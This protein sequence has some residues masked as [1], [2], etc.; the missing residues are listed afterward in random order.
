MDHESPEVIS[1]RMAQTRRDLTEKVVTLEGVVRDAVRDTSSAVRDQFRSTVDGAKE[2]ADAVAG[3]VR[4]ALDVSG[5]VRSHPWPMVAGSFTAGFITGCLPG[6]ASAPAAHTA[7][8]S[9]PRPAGPLDT[10]LSR[11]TDELSKS[12]LGLIQSVSAGLQRD[13]PGRLTR[14]MDRLDEP[15]AR[16]THPI[17]RWNGAVDDG[18]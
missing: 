18:T 15:T 11:I 7:V 14:L 1:E 13:I 4:S 9:P 3:H 8:S 10:F 17:G 6:R 2:V 16:H 12:V 5:H